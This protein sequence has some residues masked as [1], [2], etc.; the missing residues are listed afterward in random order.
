VVRISSNLVRIALKGNSGISGANI[1]VS[2]CRALIDL[3]LKDESLHIITTALGLVRSENLRSLRI[4]VHTGKDEDWQKL[5]VVL[6]GVHFAHLDILRICYSS[7]DRP[8]PL[9]QVLLQPLQRKAL[10]WKEHYLP[11]R[12]ELRINEYIH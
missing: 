2:S 10:I 8:T 3:R 12:A 11:T 4:E 7:N 6:T 9:P 5:G 1:D